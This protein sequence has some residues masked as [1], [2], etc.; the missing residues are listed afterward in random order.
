MAS[1]GVHSG[2]GD[3]GGTADEVREQL[4]NCP[5][6][7]GRYRYSQLIIAQ[8]AGQFTDPAAGLSV[9]GVEHGVR[10]VGWG[11]SGSVLSVSVSAGSRGVRRG[12]WT[13][14]SFDGS[15]HPE[16]IRER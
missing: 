12:R 4:M 1:C 14:D 7:R 8:L 11:L 13:R 2:G 9:R 3:V 5:S 15:D 6:R 10:P 16:I